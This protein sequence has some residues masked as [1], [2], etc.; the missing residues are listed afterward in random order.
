MSLT[1]ITARYCRLCS[2]SKREAE[3]CRVPN[4]SLHQ[5]WEIADAM[6]LAMIVRKHCLACMG[7]SRKLVKECSITGCVLYPYRMKEGGTK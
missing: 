7:G 3:R 1:E 6:Q 2:G 4:C 5:A